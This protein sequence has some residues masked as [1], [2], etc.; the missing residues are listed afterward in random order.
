MHV[1][2]E[3]SGCCER[4]GMIQVRFC[5]YL[6]PGDHGYEKH[7]IEVP[8]ATEGDYKGE[9]NGMRQPVD[10][11]DFQKW[12]NGLPKEWQTNPFHNHFIYVPPDTSD[13]EIMDIGEAFLHE[14]YIKWSCDKKIDLKNDSLPFVA[15]IH[16]KGGIDKKINSLK[17]ITLERQV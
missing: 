4:R 13:Q 3:P 1:K 15:K 2:V 5:M 16:S 10:K 11:I 14:A 7:R 6:D 12:I 9:V 8:V 17:S